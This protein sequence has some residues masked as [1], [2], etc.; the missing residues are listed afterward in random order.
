MLYCHRAVLWTQPSATNLNKMASTTSSAVL[1][2]LLLSSAFAENFHKLSSFPQT[3]KYNLVR[4][5]GPL[6]VLMA[7]NFSSIAL[8]NS[9]DEHVINVID[10]GA[11][12][13]GT[14]DSSTALQAAITA[15]NLRVFSH[16]E[17]ANNIVINL[18]AGQYMLS[19]GLL[20]SSSSFG[21]IISGGS[22]MASDAF[23]DN[24]FIITCAK[25]QNIMFRDLVIDNRHRGGGIR[26]DSVLQS[27]LV[28]VFFSHFNTYG[29][30]CNSTGGHE[31]LISGCFFEEFHWGEP[32]YNTSKT[33]KAIAMHFGQPDSHVIN[34]IVRCAKI[35]IVSRSSSNLI[36]STHIYTSC[37]HLGNDMTV[38][39]EIQY[40]SRIINSC[41][42]SNRC[43]S[44][45][46][47][48]LL[49]LYGQ[50][51]TTATSA[52]Y[53]RVVATTL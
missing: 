4:T 37:D 9:N 52:S 50:I 49:T 36:E 40:G 46:L 41:E 17:G 21:F 48:S 32:G 11:D 15:A 45:A 25:C 39:F 2:S 26:F 6:H 13:T 20:L 33:T 42:R 5:P 18:Q 14:N 44:F 51:L 10:Y 16:T 53:H 30:D 28:D 24:D 3:S 27:Q 34:T 35:G 7:A 19:K 43:S 29:V 47:V 22:L 8:A 12:P 23:D 38:G 1:L 31:L